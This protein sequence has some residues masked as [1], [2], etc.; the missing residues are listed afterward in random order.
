MTVVVVVNVVEDGNIGDGVV[1][2]LF[3]DLMVMLKMSLLLCAK[4]CCYVN[5]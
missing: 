2:A 1:H 3:V 4:Y 5:C